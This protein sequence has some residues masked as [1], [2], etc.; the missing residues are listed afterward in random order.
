MRILI[1]GAGAAGLSLAAL[2]AESERAHDITVVERGRRDE[3][4]G[5]GI[6][7]RE[8]AMSFLGLGEMLPGVHLSGRAMWLDGEV[9]VDLP[10]PASTHLIC[11][12]RADFVAAL[13]RR[14]VSRG[15][16]VRYECDAAT[17]G[18]SELE[19]YDLV[20]AADGADS[21]IRRRYE[22]QFRPELVYGANRYGWF[23]VDTPLSK[24]TIMLPASRAGLAWGYKYSDT[25]S[26][27]IVEC[28]EAQFRRSGVDGLSTGDT[29]L[30][31][32]KMF[33]DELDGA[34]V[35]CGDAA[36]WMR[37]ATVT[38]ARLRHRNVVLIGDAAHTTHFSQGIGT[39]F[40]FD[41]VTTLH[42]A[43]EEHGEAAPALE[44]YEA[45]Q[46]PKIT[47]FQQIASTSMRWSEELLDHAE[48]GD[49]AQVRRLVEARWP[50]NTV[51]PGPMN[52]GDR[53]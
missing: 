11:F 47:E 52:S 36:R 38:N 50:G 1:A 4:P 42:A 35:S 21:S 43:L 8:E 22:S 41:D 53:V 24:L 13:T 45:T 48:Q 23:G 5:F 33:S 16:R 44:S 34:S 39:M 30:E 15:V 19:D 18:E 14:C 25:S 27:F 46:Q 10:N 17:L 32:A 40:A 28:N 29:A 7:V 9:V 31:I 20:V 3:R 26:T 12:S 6:T 51:P 2:L 49:D 37:F